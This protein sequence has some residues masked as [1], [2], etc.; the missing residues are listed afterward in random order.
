M[1]AAGAVQNATR[2]CRMHKEGARG[3]GPRRRLAAA[4]ALAA[5]SIALTAAPA[6]LAAAANVNHFHNVGSDV[7]PDFCGTGVAINFAFDFRG[8]EWFAPHNADYKNVQ[9]GAVT[10]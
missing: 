2:R 9:T 10:F 1:S 3:H 7:D 4:M 5:A 8:T 6:A